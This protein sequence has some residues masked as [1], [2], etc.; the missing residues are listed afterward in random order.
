MNEK[1]WKCKKVI[2]EKI[3]D[4][5]NNV[6]RNDNVQSKLRNIFDIIENEFP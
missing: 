3:Y 1:L 2:F 4:L 5:K 6:L